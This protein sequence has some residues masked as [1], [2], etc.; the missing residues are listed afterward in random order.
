[1]NMKRTLR[2]RLALLTRLLDNEPLAGD[3]IEECAHRPRSWFWRQLMFAIM[4]RAA[5]SA[6]AHFRDPSRLEEPLASLAVFGVL[7]FQVVVA[8]SLLNAL[9]PAGRIERP[10]WLTFGVL[11]SF[12]VAWLT[13]KALSRLRPKHR[14]ATVVLCGASAAGAALTIAS[15]L[16]SSAAVFF[17]LAGVQVGAA[18]VFVAGLLAG[19]V[20]ADSS[21]HALGSGSNGMSTSV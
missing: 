10:E 17:P 20:R 21:S 1:M 15:M 2:L 11:L 7:C 14:L 12:P 19:T 13:G 9:L 18:A 3:L 16:T 6:V 8:G 5:T 4:G